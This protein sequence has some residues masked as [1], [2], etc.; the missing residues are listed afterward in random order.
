MVYVKV[1][2]S[3]IVWNAIGVKYVGQTRNKINRFGDHI[4]DIKHL[5]NK[6]VARNFLRH[7]D[8]LDPKMII[9][10]LEYIKLPKDIPRSHSLRITGR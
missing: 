7:N 1:V 6:T 10:I 5:N 9:H 4:F 2:T 3:F 8:Q